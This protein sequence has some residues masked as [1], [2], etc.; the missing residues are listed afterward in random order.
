MGKSFLQLHFF[1][2]PS[3]SRDI[4]GKPPAV[5]NPRENPGGSP[6]KTICVIS[7]MEDDTMSNSIK[8]FGK[9]VFLNLPGYGFDYGGSEAKQ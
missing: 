7:A 2:A 3:C 1:P 4:P 6:E 5:K 9:G 8:L